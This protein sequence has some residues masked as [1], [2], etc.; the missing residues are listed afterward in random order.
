MTEKEKAKVE[1]LLASCGGCAHCSFW[2]QYCE[3]HDKKVKDSDPACV[4]FKSY[5]PFIIRK[6]M[7]PE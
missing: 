7:L 4:D 6:K 3:K 5:E 1:Y 2:E